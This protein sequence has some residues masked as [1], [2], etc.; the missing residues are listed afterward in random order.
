MSFVI[1]AP[2]QTPSSSISDSVWLHDFSPAAFE[3]DND[4]ISSPGKRDRAEVT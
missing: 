2:K 3:Y 1:E 4:P